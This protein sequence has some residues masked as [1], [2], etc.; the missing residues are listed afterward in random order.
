MEVIQLVSRIPFPLKSGGSIHSYLN[1]KA[2]AEQ[3]CSVTM[4]AINTPKHPAS[5][6]NLPPAFSDGRIDLHI[7]DVDTNVKPL[8][9]FKNLFTKESYNVSRFYSPKYERA[10]IDLLKTKKPD[11]A[12]LE[13]IFMMPYVSCIRKNSAAR[14]VLRSHNVEHLI[15]Q[16]L[17]KE[18][19]RGLRKW[20]LSFLAKRL[21][22]Y[23]STVLSSVDA[24][25]AIS[26]EDASK[27]RS[28]GE[29]PEIFVSPPGV[30]PKWAE[31]GNTITKAQNFFFI[32]SMDWLPNREGMTWLTNEVWP[33]LPEES[34]V[35]LTV[36]GKGLDKAF[37]GEHRRRGI[38]FTPEAED[39]RIFMLQHDILLVP[40]L[41]GS[42]VRI[43]ILEALSL[44]RAVVS[45]S[46]GAEGLDLRDQE[47][48]IIADS[49]K[50]FANAIMR[51]KKHPEIA[52]SLARGGRDWVLKNHDNKKLNKALLEFYSGLVNEARA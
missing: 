20:Y 38:N 13:G 51:L 6:H 8:E 9:A 16:G 3:G 40:L 12:Q 37:V 28:L 34:D 21:K 7:I 33:L 46:L 30:N 22:A 2:L 41:S 14:I 32:G 17:A 27:L 35:L 44:G 39:A 29:T 42:G 23:E 5:I 4:L 48:I 18:E 45:T 19:K 15:W 49:A 25:V 10:L 50:A 36:T 52:S 43:K 1:A 24:I 31:K 11:V 47:H 26:G